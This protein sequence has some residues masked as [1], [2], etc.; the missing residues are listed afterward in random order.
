MVHA[1]QWREQARINDQ[2][3]AVY[4]KVIKKGIYDQVK[5]IYG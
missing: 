4:E 5:H 3:T 1:F 2:V